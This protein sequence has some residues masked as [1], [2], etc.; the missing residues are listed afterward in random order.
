MP[1]GAFPQKERA[2]FFIDQPKFSTTPSVFP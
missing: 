1:S 2:A